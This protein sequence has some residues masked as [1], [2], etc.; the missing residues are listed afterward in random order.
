MSIIRENYYFTS[1]QAADQIKCYLPY[2]RVSL[3]SIQNEWFFQDIA[4]RYLYT[5]HFL[6]FLLK[7]IF[8]T[9]RLPGPCLLNLIW[10]NMFNTKQ[11]HVYTYKTYMYHVNCQGSHPMLYIYRSW[12]SYKK[13]LWYMSQTN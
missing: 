2:W 5:R 9:C 1:K 11:H 13:R 12:Y 3:I 10:V 4:Q 7:M 8:G 6:F